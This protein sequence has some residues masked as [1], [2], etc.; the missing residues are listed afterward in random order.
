MKAAAAL[1]KNTAAVC[2]IFWQYPIA[3]FLEAAAKLIRNRVR[4]LQQSIQS[5]NK[6]ACIFIP[7]WSR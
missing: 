4:S 7:L 6:M 5:R 3:S 2:K 1:R